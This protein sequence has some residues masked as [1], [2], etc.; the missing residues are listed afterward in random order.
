MPLD[1]K[2]ADLMLTDFG[3]WESTLD[4]R[5]RQILDNTF[6]NEVDRDVAQKRFAA[7]NHIAAYTGHDAQ[8]VSRRFEDWYMPAFARDE[9][10]GFGS[11]EGVKDFGEFYGLLTERARSNNQKRE[12]E[13]EAQTSAIQAALAGRPMLDA[14]GEWQG[15][16]QGPQEA[17]RMD[18]TPAFMQAYQV[19]ASQVLKYQDI[20]NSVTK[21]LKGVMG[22]HE[23]SPEYTKFL[24][25]GGSIADDKLPDFHKFDFEKAIDTLLE[26]PEEDRPMVLH[27]I[28]LKQPSTGA[29][30]HVAARLAQF[31]ERGMEPLL[32]EGFTGAFNQFGAS[33]IDAILPNDEPIT[34]EERAIYYPESIEA[35]KKQKEYEVLRVQLRN[36][37]NGLV[38]IKPVTLLGMNLGGAAQSAPMTLASFIPYV[39]IPL[40]IGQFRQEGIGNLISENPGMSI[41]DAESIMNLAAPIMGMTEFFTDRLLFGKLPAFGKFMSSPLLTPSG[42]MKR[43]GSRVAVGVPTEMLEENIQKATPLLI[44]EMFAAFKKDVPGVDWDA[45][46]EEFKGMQLDTFA[47]A[48]PMVLIGAGVGSIVDIK[49]GKTLVQDKT[50]MVMSGYSPEVASQIQ[51]TVAKGDLKGAELMMRHGSDT[52]TPEQQAAAAQDFSKRV[53]LQKKAIRSLELNGTLATVRPVANGWQ[54]R[55]ERGVLAEFPTFEAADA[56]RWA[57][58]RRRNLDIHEIYRETI[59]RVERELKIGQENI[60]IFSDKIL[61][62]EQ[63][64]ERGLATQ[65]DQLSKRKA[66]SRAL[67]EGKLENDTYRQ[68][69][70]E[71]AAEGDPTPAYVILGANSIEHAD[72]VSR[73]IIRLFKGAT[74]HDL[75]EEFAEVGVKRAT[76]PE[77]RRDLLSSLRDAEAKLQAAETAAGETVTPLFR[78]RNDAEI[79]DS[80]IIEA[81]SHVAKSYYS[82]ETEGK[83]TRRYIQALRKAVIGSGAFKW[84]NALGAKLGNVMKRAEMIRQVQKGPGFT[85]E[86]EALIRQSIGLKNTTASSVDGPRTTQ[87]AHV[88]AVT[89]EVE[90]ISGVTFSLR[91]GASL[92]SQKKHIPKAAEKMPV[93]Q[94]RGTFEQIVSQ[95]VDWMRANPVAV[96]PDGKRILIESPEKGS[97]ETRAEHW[98]GSFDPSDKWQRQ[99]RQVRLDKV[100]SIAAIPTTLQGAQVKARTSNNKTVY[101]RRYAGNQ[102]HAVFVNEFDTVTAHGMIN[103]EAVTQYTLDPTRGIEGAEVVTDWTT[104]APAY[105]VNPAKTQGA[106]SDRVSTPG[107]QPSDQQGDTSSPTAQGYLTSQGDI[108]NSADASDGETTFSLSR[109]DDLEAVS[110]V[111][112]ERSAADPQMRPS[113]LQRA[114]EHLAAARRAW[115]AHLEN[116]ASKPNQES[117]QR[118]ALRSLDAVLTLLPPEARA[119]LGGFIQTEALTTREARQAK[120]EKRLDQLADFL[121]QDGTAQGPAETGTEEAQTTEPGVLGSGSSFSLTPM[122]AEALRSAM[123][124][125]DLPAPILERPTP[126][127]AFQWWE[128]NMVGRVIRTPI[129]LSFHVNAGHFFRFVASKP[130]GKQKGFISGYDTAT[131]AMQAL[132]EGRIDMNQLTGWQDMRASHLPIVED[133]LTAPDYVLLERQEGK[134][135]LKFVKRYKGAWGV[136]GF[137][138]EDGKFAPL[139]FSPRK[140][141]VGELAGD[142]L[143]YASPELEGMQNTLPALPSNHSGI[144]QGQ[145]PDSWVT[146]YPLIE[147]NVKVDTSFSLSRVRPTEELGGGEGA[148][149]A[150][151]AGTNLTLDPSSGAVVQEPTDAL[152]LQEEILKLREVG[153]DYPHAID[154]HFRGN[155]KASLPGRVVRLKSGQVGTITR[156]AK[157]QTLTVNTGSELV[158][159]LRQNEV[160]M[161][162]SPDELAAEKAFIQR[163]K[164]FQELKG[165]YDQ[166]LREIAQALPE[167][168]PLLPPLKGAPR[169]L[170]KAAKIIARERAMQRERPAEQVLAG[171]FDLL[172]GSI[173][174]DSL[175]Q[176][177]EAQEAILGAFLPGAVRKARRANGDWV[178]EAPDGRQATLADRFETPTQGGYSDLQIILEME[179]GY[180]VE[181]QVHLPEMLAV[182]DGLAVKQMGVPEK[183]WPQ[184]LH[185]EGFDPAHPEHHLYEEARALPDGSPEAAAIF[186]KIRECYQ[187]AWAAYRRRTGT[188]RGEARIKRD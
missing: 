162:L 105:S 148:A 80:D 74:P 183:Y 65:Q 11:K 157:D 109:G 13:T 106:E 7:V 179:P 4:E 37:G 164:H 30:D 69:T 102:L 47:T 63:A 135:T 170:E 127:S 38:P 45:R 84:I 129:G 166:R 32:V 54:V 76:T 18:M 99:S 9:S 115:N 98:M 44:Q 184:N 181:I 22:N 67:D 6:R 82:N 34:D 28:A 171:F 124:R 163:L 177:A 97:L 68:A 125:R 70:A 153:A 180:F 60:I 29:D 83:H 58:A 33:L 154:G 20:V 143:M 131:E 64:V 5:Q 89:Q 178:Y 173:L 91:K 128:N 25:S 133:L 8:E 159:G 175:S 50:I 139:S 123:P 77:T 17:G 21:D 134:N 19:Q 16:S 66:Q 138:T 137:G 149:V 62:P 46:Y 42:L 55:N 93:F 188:R 112:D 53:K 94:A 151:D 111:L 100:A 120:I 146:N 10:V 145:D 172:R 1:P 101:L 110:A 122:A 12:W 136:I 132:R 156:V 87:Q 155:W 167:A 57:E 165:T 187:A 147:G 118:Q 150:G 86:L 49:N 26:V 35:E 126:Q 169:G 41:N 152:N 95:V 104:V 117:A 186:Q 31:F 116:P 185:I 176:V 23:F 14:L 3:A 78:T 96:A 73:A 168:H 48:L 52:A 85:P 36:I 72:G 107:R 119:R 140:L 158:S 71:A 130:L 92:N 88:A 113:L 75:I 121:P 160:M 142:R 51:E 114:A 59:S 24:Q 161:E 174:V 27:A 79:E 61:T 103:G 90:E 39:G 56:A 2:T 43:F 81:F 40:M 15:L 182:K 108:V 144:W 141:K